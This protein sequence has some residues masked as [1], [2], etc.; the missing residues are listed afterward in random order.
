MGGIAV[1]AGGCW[2]AACANCHVMRDYHDGWVKSSHRSV[3]ACND[4]HIPHDFIGKYSAKALNLFFHS[5]A[6]TIGRPPE[7]IETK[8]QLGMLMGQQG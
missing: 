7:A 4:C 2:P 1:L 6:F 8:R 3:A 5:F